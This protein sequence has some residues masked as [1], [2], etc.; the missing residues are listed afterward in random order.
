[1]IRM[2]QVLIVS[3]AHLELYDLDSGKYLRSLGTGI[4][5]V[6][7][8]WPSMQVLTGSSGYNCLRV[9]NVETGKCLRSFGNHTSYV[10]AIVADW[11]K[12]EH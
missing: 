10:Q 12:S 6:T 8:D 11:Q 4:C 9:W 1:M 5:S 3:D 2:R 7:A